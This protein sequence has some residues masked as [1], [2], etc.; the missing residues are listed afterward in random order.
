[1]AGRTFIVDQVIDLDRDMFTTRNSDVHLGVPEA[2]KVQP[3]D[4]I[5]GTVRFRGGHFQPI[6]YEPFYI[7]GWIAAPGARV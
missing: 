4:T 6:G 1:M 7:Y 2:T 5:D 3:G